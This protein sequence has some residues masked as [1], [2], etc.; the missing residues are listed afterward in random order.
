MLGIIGGTSLLFAELPDLKKTE[1]ATPYGTAELYLGDIALLLRHQHEMP[2]HQINF[3]ACISA[4]AIAGVDRAV[5][6]GSVGSLNKSIRPGSIII[7]DDYLSMAPVPTIHNHTQEHIMPAIDAGLS[8]EISSCIP[9][10]E[11]GGT[12]VQTGGPRIETKA[13]VRALSEIGDLVGMTIASEATLCNELDIAFSAICMVDN[14][15][16]GIGEDELSYEQILNFARAN[17][18]KTEMI[19]ERIITRIG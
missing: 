1:I 8:R 6:F 18:K 17:T 13:E 14:Y 2:P 5:A 9:E 15:A 4:L 16:H 12:Y 19:L 7:P 11:I 10:S 3:P